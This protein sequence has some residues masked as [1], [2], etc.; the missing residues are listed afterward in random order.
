V[1]FYR[2]RVAAKPIRRDLKGRFFRR[3]L[4]ARVFTRPRP[5]PVIH[6]CSNTTAACKAQRAIRAVTA[7]AV[8]VHLSRGSRLAPPSR[9]S[10]FAYYHSVTR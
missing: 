4:S 9:T 7:R 2:S 10:L 5:S 6:G 1:S 3:P 8:C